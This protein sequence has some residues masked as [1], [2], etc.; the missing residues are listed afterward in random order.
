LEVSAEGKKGAQM[1]DGIIF[2]ILGVWV[3]LIGLGKARVSKN[4]ALGAAW[5]KK[6]GLALRICGP[7]MALAGIV[8]II[9][10]L[11]RR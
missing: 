10:D 3:L 9:A 11:A 4:P 6:W 1:I 8:R 7:L 2:V 5:L